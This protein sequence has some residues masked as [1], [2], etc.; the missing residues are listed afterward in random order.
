MQNHHIVSRF[1][2]NF[3]VTNTDWLDGTCKGNI[4]IQRYYNNVVLVITQCINHGHDR[5]ME[6]SMFPTLY[7]SH[8]QGHVTQKV[9]LLGLTL[10]FSR[11]LIQ[12]LK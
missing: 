8:T 12:V 7:P 11:V 2:F 1:N 5:I 3:R 10:D 4:P 9:T 6:I